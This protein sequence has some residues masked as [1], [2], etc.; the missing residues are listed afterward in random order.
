MLSLAPTESSHTFRKSCFLYLVFI[1]HICI[2][3]SSGLLRQTPSKNMKLE[4][5]FLIHTERHVFPW[6]PKWKLHLPYAHPVTHAF[7]IAGFPLALSTFPPF[8]LVF[9]SCPRAT[10]W[11]W[12]VNH[13]FPRSIENL[14]H[15][16]IFPFIFQKRF[17]SPPKS[18][19]CR[20]VFPTCSCSL[21]PG[22]TRNT[23]KTF[24]NTVVFPYWSFT[25]IW[26][27][28]KKRKQKT[29]ADI[30]KTFSICYFDQLPK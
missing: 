28:R 3:I 1:T 14:L 20:D 11:G 6:L 15:G 13:I 22:R 24:S 5:M 21:I 29:L 2:V 10:K 18:H 30:Q 4:S 12:N 7:P 23:N 9:L 19:M 16:S 26:S 17:L 27:K 8:P 25:F